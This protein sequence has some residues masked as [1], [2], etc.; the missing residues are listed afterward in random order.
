MPLAGLALRG[1]LAGFVWWGMPSGAHAQGGRD[2]VRETTPLPQARHFHGSAVL[3]DYLYVFGGADGSQQP[4][5]ST[6]FARINND[7]SVSQWS[8]TTPLPHPRM[9]LANS[10][11]VLNDTVYLL[12]GARDPLAEDYLNTVLI[13]RPGA[14][15][16]LSRWVESPPFGSGAGTIAAVTTPG[17]LHAIGG[18]GTSAQQ[19]D[20]V[21]DEVWTCEV[22]ADGMLGTWTAG[23]K[24]PVA[25]W[26]HN[27]AA[28]GGRVWVWGGLRTPQP[29]PAT[30]ISAFVFSA[31]I[32]ADGQ[33]GTW[34]AEAQQLPRPFYSSTSGVVGP[35]LLAVAP[36][37]GINSL[38]SDVWWSIVGADGLSPWRA[39][40]SES[41]TNRVYHPT[42]YDYRRGY[43]Y[44]AGGRA[45]KTNKTPSNKTLALILSPEVRR[46]GEKSWQDAEQR[47]T[48]TV[49]QSVDEQLA[50]RAASATG[51]SLSYL[52]AGELPPE[53]PTGFVTHQVA[54]EDQG[55]PETKPLVIYFRMGG[56][57][58]A[59]DQEA[60]MRSEEFRGL[61]QQ[62]T[63]VWIDV[64]Q[65]PQMAQQHGVF[66]VPTWLFFD[67]QKGMKVGRHTGTLTLA[68]L[69][70]LVSMAGA[71]TPVAGASANAKRGG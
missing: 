66:R 15:G 58:P 18:L 59:M 8:D 1:I 42:A 26:Y 51:G 39:S 17:H 65:Q 12:G 50:S 56:A 54:I 2:F 32:R 22:K 11:L 64:E 14:D 61:A 63:F 37:Y 70:H 23:P 46:A 33:L 21:L 44:V 30:S 9:Y 57:K 49:S 60:A 16:R 5:L 20:V 29:D 62:A 3:G 69:A 71:Q 28:A 13:A 6:H 10:T 68:E 40:V 55:Q 19:K 47:H 31:P 4:L 43:I 45:A 48:M 41:L 7:G 36:R 27:A 38:S 34:R 52:V 35:Y 25:L 67:G 24:L 53:A